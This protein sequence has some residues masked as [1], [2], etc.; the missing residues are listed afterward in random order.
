MFK[1]PQTS[2]TGDDKLVLIESARDI[3]AFFSLITR[4]YVEEQSLYIDDIT[5]LAQLVSGLRGL[6]ELLRKYDCEAHLK[7][8][9]MYIQQ[10]ISSDKLLG[11][12]LKLALRMGWQDIALSCINKGPIGHLS[13]VHAYGGSF[14]EF[15]T[16][17]T[18]LHP[19]VWTLEDVEYVGLKTYHAYV[20]C[21]GQK[22]PAWRDIA[23]RFSEMKWMALM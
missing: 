3:S 18:D 9:R 2:E 15:V 23:T 13:L 7:L 11:E 17:A 1:L 21:C 8:V 10:L 22:A 20:Q 14:K 16:T 12:L 4:F 19:A 5:D 6:V